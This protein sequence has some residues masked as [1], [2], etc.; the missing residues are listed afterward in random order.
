MTLITKQ[1]CPT[2][3]YFLLL[4]RNS[5]ICTLSLCSHLNARDWRFKSIWSRRKNWAM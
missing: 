1:L 4:Y 3:C 2:S 5:F